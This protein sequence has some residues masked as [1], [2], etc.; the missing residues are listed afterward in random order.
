MTR[1]VFD[2]QSG[3]LV[4]QQRRIRRAPPLCNLIAGSGPA[5]YGSA[6]V[7]YTTLN[8]ADKQTNLTLSGGN[9]IATANTN[10]SGF[11]R[12]VHYKSSGK[13][14]F[15]AV[16]TTATQGSDTI[17]VGFGTS[18]AAGGNSNAL[19]YSTSQ[20]WAIWGHG[21]GGSGWRN[22][23][24]VLSATSAQGDV[25]G[26]CLDL[27]AGKVWVLK[28]NTSLQ[29]DPVAGTSPL[30]TNISATGPVAPAACPWKVPHVIT[31]RFDP[32]SFSYSTPSGYTP[33]WTAV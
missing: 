12:A 24:L 19:A 9:L 2:Q 13:W 1:Y 25:F 8:P 7:T 17:A 31:M 14:Y 28:N 30:S 3:L 33:G 23:G 6:A 26:F 4:P 21:G 20:G 32:A 16:L 18:I 10:N 15:E 11:C 5:F 27:D 22:S 29:G